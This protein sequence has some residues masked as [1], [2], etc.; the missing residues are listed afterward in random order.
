MHLRVSRTAYIV[1]TAVACVFFF[2]LAVVPGVYEETSPHLS[3]PVSGEILRDRG[4]VLG[5]HGLRRELHFLGSTF[6]LSFHVVLRKLYSIVAFGLIA[7]L[8]QRAT[9][10]RGRR[11]WW[12]VG[13]LSLF[14]AAIEV[15]Q[16]STTDG[17]EGLGWNLFDVACGAVGGWLGAW[18][19]ARLSGVR[20]RSV[21]SGVVDRTIESEER[22]R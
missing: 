1:L 6:K 19:D 9:G 13:L 16:L 17:Q 20:E 11:V 22:E 2:V 12:T 8:L 14:S 3:G 18:S 10:W 15:A 21:G 7:L 5:H 4:A